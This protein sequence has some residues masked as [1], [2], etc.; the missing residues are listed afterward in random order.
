MSRLFNKLRILYLFN[1]ILL[2]QYS[3]VSLCR[4]HESEKRIGY[5]SEN[6]DYQPGNALI[7]SRKRLFEGTSSSTSR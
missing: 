4:R 3:S 7:E 1:D 5:T 2:S 6:D